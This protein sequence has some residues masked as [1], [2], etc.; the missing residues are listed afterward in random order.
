MVG[1]VQRVK[2]TSSLFQKIYGCT[3]YEITVGLKGTGKGAPDNVV[4]K[5]FAMNYLA[6]FS[7]L[8]GPEG[9]TI[10]ELGQHV[11][12]YLKAAKVPGGKMRY[13]VLHPNGTKI[14]KDIDKTG[15]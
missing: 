10:P 7:P 15:N 14:L 11:R 13:E 6:P 3:D 2:K 9:H 12:L 4:Y 5:A 8:A 1:K